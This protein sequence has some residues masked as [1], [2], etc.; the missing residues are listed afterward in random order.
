ME[1]GNVENAI[2]AKL[3]QPESPLM[4]R[5]TRNNQILLHNYQAEVIKHCQCVLEGCERTFGIVLIPNQILYPK[6][7]GEHRSEFRREFH[8]Q[9][10]PALRQA[11]GP[12]VVE[13]LRTQEKEF[14]A[15]AL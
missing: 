8:L 12:G 2:L 11:Q 15:T 3:E 13:K 10:H 1:T 5:V 7:C 9:Q 6:F 14:S 4:Q